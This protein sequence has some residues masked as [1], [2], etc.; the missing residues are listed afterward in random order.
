MIPLALE[1]LLWEALRG[2]GE[3]RL[4]LLDK[5]VVAVVAEVAGGAID[6]GTFMS[7]ALVELLFETR[8]VCRL[9]D[10]LLTEVFRTASSFFGAGLLSED[11][12]EMDTP[13][14]HPCRDGSLDLISSF[15]GDVAR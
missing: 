3:F 4:D 13:L 12:R 10:G 6:V 15:N 7:C 9:G 1:L 14:E 5:L 2:E 11:R 8:R